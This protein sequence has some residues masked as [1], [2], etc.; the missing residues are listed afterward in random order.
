MTKSELIKRYT[1]FIISLFFSAL[2]V[3]FTKHGE[4]G[5][6]PTSSIAN[7]ISCKYTA[8]SLGTPAHHLE[9]SPDPRSD[10]DSAQELSMDPASADSAFFPFRMV[11][12]FRH[13]DGFLCS[14]ESL[15]R[16]A[17]YDP[18]WRYDS[19]LRSLAFCH[20]QCYPQFRGSLCKSSLRHYPYK[21]FQ[22]E[23]YF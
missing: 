2:G 12:G 22:Y 1:L 9:L 20:C 11:Y 15:S 10:F 13:V 21:L 18:D 14:C 19:R 16:P 8:W 5:V 7:V 23:N 17:V 4:L 6:S 3:A